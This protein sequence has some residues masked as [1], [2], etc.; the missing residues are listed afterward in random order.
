MSQKPALAGQVG[1]THYT[2]MKIPPMEFSM[3]NGWD[4]CSHT[5]LKYLSRYPNKGG[6]EDLR[7]AAHTIRLRQE[8]GGVLP[9]RASLITAQD[10]C[11]AN[12]FT[13]HQTAMIKLL[14]RIVNH[15]LD[16]TSAE[17]LSLIEHVIE[18]LEDQR[19]NH[20]VLNGPTAEHYPA[21]KRPEASIEKKGTGWLVILANG[22]AFGPFD[23]KDKA[24]DWTRGCGLEPITN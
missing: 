12:G 9:F 10:Y 8:L 20:I 13:L 23:T 5:A 14:E 7:K 24:C 11:V 16:A 17:L 18:D 4:A 6:V 3:A 21:P 2:S 22:S 19:M 1:G 15:C